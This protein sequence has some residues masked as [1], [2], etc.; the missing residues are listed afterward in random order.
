MRAML[1]LCAVLAAGGLGA[2]CPIE[3]TVRYDLH[4]YAVTAVGGQCWFAQNLRATH[5]SNG[6]PIPVVDGA[7]MW[8]AGWPA[9]SPSVVRAGTPRR[10]PEHLE[11]YGL[12]Y[13]G[14]VAIDARGVCPVG[15]RVPTHEDWIRLEMALGCGEE[16][17][18]GFGFRGGTQG[19]QL[20]KTD[21]ELEQWVGVD[22]FGWAALPGGFRSANG[23]DFNLGDSSYYWSSTPRSARSLYVRGLTGHREDMYSSE[24]DLAEGC[25]IRCV[26]G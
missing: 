12:Y 9:H 16:V 19:T 22:A 8:N 21:P 17:A 20:R 14:H 25:S 13:N 1:F 3:G 24:K 10:K 23:E 11:R 6:D 26:K 5:F 7:G 2:Q 15:W 4:T 18:R